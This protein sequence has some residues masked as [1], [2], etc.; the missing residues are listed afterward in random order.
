SPK[1][2]E[3]HYDV[4]AR[5][6]LL[7]AKLNRGVRYVQGM[8]ELCAPLY[9]LFAQDPLHCR[10][11]EADTFF[12]FSLLMSDMRDA[13]VKTMDNEEGGMMGRIDKFSELLREKDEEV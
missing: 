12:C 1:T 6:L 4:L 11:A 7:Y 5:V 13:F 2:T 8:N 10:H 9:Y 3:G